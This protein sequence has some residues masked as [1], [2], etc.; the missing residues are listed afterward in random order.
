M[1]GKLKCSARIIGTKNGFT[2]SKPQHNH[3]PMDFPEEKARRSFK[4]DKFNEYY[5]NISGG[6]AQE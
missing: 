3:E 6:D 5:A 2:L 1:N 4:L